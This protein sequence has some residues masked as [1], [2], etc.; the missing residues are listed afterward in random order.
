MRLTV[1][2]ADLAFFVYERHSARPLY[3]AGDTLCT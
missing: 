1:M 2:V 3:G